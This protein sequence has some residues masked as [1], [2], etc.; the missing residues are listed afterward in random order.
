MSARYGYCGYDTVWPTL[1]VTEH[2]Q[3][4]LMTELGC[5]EGD[6]LAYLEA[7]ELEIVLAQKES[8]RIATAHEDRIT[9]AVPEVWGG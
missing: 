4:S 6:I 7:H 1:P 2:A 8:P 5:V 9:E 3:M